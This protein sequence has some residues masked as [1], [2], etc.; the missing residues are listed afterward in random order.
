MDNFWCVLPTRT[1]RPRL[2]LGNRNFVP[3]SLRSPPCSRRHMHSPSHTCSLRPTRPLLGGRARLLSRPTPPHAAAAH[4]RRWPRPTHAPACASSSP[5]ASACAR[6]QVVVPP[7]PSPAA[8]ARRH[9]PRPFAPPPPSQR[10]RMRL[11]APHAPATCTRRWPHST[12]V[13]AASTPPHV[14]PPRSP[15][16]P[17]LPPRVRRPAAG[18]RV[19]PRPWRAGC[20]GPR[21]GRAQAVR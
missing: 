18:P 9:G 3:R 14:A 6:S 11:L 2:V 10:L 1:V 13:P 16:A 21:R 20:C 4:A 15:R 5:N 19:Q 8:A 17:P 12:H 7:R